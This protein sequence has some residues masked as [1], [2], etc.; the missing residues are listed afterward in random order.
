MLGAIHA[1]DLTIRNPE[2]ISKVL[3]KK[4]SDVAETEHY[5]ASVNRDES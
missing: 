1:L 3:S 4:Q 5:I 2:K